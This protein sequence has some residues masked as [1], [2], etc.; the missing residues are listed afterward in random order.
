[1]NYK[2]SRSDW[3]KIGNKMGWLKSAY[4]PDYDSSTEDGSRQYKGSKTFK[5]CIDLDERGSFR[6]SVRDEDGKVHFSVLGGNEIEEGES[7]LVD[8][9]YMRHFKD[10]K[11]LESYLKD[12]NIISQ[13]DRL[14]MKNKGNC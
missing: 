4:S 2:I 10:I 14:V 12:M 1:M 6:A 11:G 3:E 5:Y 9:G 13:D 7:S 8:D